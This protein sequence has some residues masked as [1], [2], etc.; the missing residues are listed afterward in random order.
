MSLF[1]KLKGVQELLIHTDLHFSASELILLEIEIIGLHEDAAWVPLLVML[2]LVV[3]V[4]GHDRAHDE[5]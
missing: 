1:A 3:G 4:N 5:L 2:P